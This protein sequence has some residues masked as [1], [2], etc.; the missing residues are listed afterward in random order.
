MS[1]EGYTVDKAQAKQLLQTEKGWVQLA[2]ENE[3]STIDY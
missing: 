2:L 1:Y 3:V